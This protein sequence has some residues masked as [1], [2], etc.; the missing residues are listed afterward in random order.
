[1][2]GWP[3][4]VARAVRFSCLHTGRRHGDAA[5]RADGAVAVEPGCVV[6]DTSS[7][8]LRSSVDN[9]WAA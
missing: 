1:M 3:P 6:R 4:T 2:S 7:L 5:G 8:R 9:A